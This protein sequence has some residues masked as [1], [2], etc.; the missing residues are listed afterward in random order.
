[1]VPPSAEQM[2]TPAAL[3][4]AW[5]SVVA[6]F[7]FTRARSITITYSGTST[8]AHAPKQKRDVMVHLKTSL[9]H[10]AVTVTVC[11]VAGVLAGVPGWLSGGGGVGA[12]PCA[13]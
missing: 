10:H 13:F 2:D 12:G 7:E 6:L 8:K 11:M 5:S 3:R 4:T 1:M 9:R